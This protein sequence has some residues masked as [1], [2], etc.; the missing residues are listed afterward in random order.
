MIHRFVYL[1]PAL[2]LVLIFIG[3]KVLATGALGVEKIPAML[4]LS[5][6][7]MILAGAVVLS[8]WRTR[9]AAIAAQPSDGKSQ[10]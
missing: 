1:K 7:V 10:L 8:T 9:P 5:V 2:S 4:S 6:T 3:G